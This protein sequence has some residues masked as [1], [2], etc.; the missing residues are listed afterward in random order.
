MIYKAARNPDN[1]MV[2]SLVSLPNSTNELVCT[3]NLFPPIVWQ[4]VSTNVA[5]PDGNWQ[6]TDT[7]TV[8]NKVQFYRSRT[9]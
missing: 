3:T 4:S 6:F 7:N 9:H 5:G 2:I 1:S 8:N